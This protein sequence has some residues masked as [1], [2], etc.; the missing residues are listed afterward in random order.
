MP[1]ILCGLC[2]AFAQGALAQEADAKT[3]KSHERVIPRFASFKHAKTN[4]RVGPG[5]KYPI[6]WIYKKRG[7][8]VEIIA[9]FANWRRIRGSDGLDGWVSSILLSPTRTALVSPWSDDEVYLRSSPDP[10]GAIVARLE[11]H[12]LVRLHWCNRAWCSVSLRGGSYEGYVRQVKL[13]GVYPNEVIKGR[14][15]WSAFQD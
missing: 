4:V 6:R 3:K 2:A 9:E 13:W 12:V 15:L 8:P 10:K 7:H 5:T 14:S 11:P 1:V